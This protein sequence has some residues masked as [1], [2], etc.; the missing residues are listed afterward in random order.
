MEQREAQSEFGTQ[1]IFVPR[2]KGLRRFD[3]P[4]RITQNETK[5]LDALVDHILE[6]REKHQPIL[7]I[8]KND[9]ESKILHDK[10]EERLKS[11]RDQGVCPN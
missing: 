7:L 3:R 5:Q 2:H 4:T 11:K 8:C 9:N 1:F 10:L 6:S